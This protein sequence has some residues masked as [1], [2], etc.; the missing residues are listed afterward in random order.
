MIALNQYYQKVL[1]ETE[2]QQIIEIA[3]PGAGQTVSFD[4]QSLTAMHEIIGVV[5]YNPNPRTAGH[6]TLRLRIG[7]TEILPEG[8][9]ADL[10]ARFNQGE[11]NAKVGFAFKEYIFPYKTRAKG[12]PVRI[13]YSEP[14]DG[15]VGKLYLYLLGKYDNSNLPITNYRFQVLGFTVPKGSNEKDVEVPIDEKALQSCS[16]VVGAFFVGNTNRIKQVKLCID[17]TSVFPEGMAGQLVTKEMVEAGSISN[18]IFTKHL[19]PFSY[20]L[21][22]CDVKA[23]NSKVE[24]G[25]LA[26]PH[27]DKDYNVFLYLISKV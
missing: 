2:K 18:G 23:G 22:P 16:K 24:G 12:E 3:I 9:H 17:G 15:G 25:F 1:E 20:L 6:G 5:L 11:V 4:I 26:T 14:P 13:T 19:I 21:H 27:P 10:L 8:F 7:G